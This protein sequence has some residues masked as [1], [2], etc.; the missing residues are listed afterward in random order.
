MVCG[1]RNGRAR[2][3]SEFTRSAHNNLNTVGMSTC[4][5]I[6]IRD[7]S[8]SF[9]KRGVGYSSLKSA[10]VGWFQARSRGRG[11]ER[12]VLRDLTMRVPKGNSVGVIGRN[13][14]GKST[15]LKLITGI[16]T[17]DAGSIAVEG[18]IAALIEL[19]AGFHPDFTGRENLHL[20]GLLHGLT[21]REVDERFDKIVE[22]ARPTREA[23]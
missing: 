23:S 22:F 1:I 13:G 16:Y 14:S 8:K 10:V 5:V 11:G 18:R 15:L 17:A 19:G 4:Y 20:G 6:D 7:L 12:V 21:R 9:R 2:S 3:I